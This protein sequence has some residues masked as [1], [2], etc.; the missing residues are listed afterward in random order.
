MQASIFF[1]SLADSDMLAEGF[2]KNNCSSTSLSCL[3]GSLQD[4]DAD[5]LFEKVYCEYTSKV[6][7][8]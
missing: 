4:L 2:G 6:M 7:F 5:F 1:V 8:T 3:K